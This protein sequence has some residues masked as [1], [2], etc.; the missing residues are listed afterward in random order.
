[1]S[2]P[3]SNF[4]ESGTASVHASPRHSGRG[5]RHTHARRLRHPPRA[6]VRQ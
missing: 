6:Q 4:R 2:T 3:P 1:M 5:R